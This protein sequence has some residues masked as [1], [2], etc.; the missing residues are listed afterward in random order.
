[1]KIIYTQQEYDSVLIKKI[2]EVKTWNEI[3]DDFGDSV[4]YKYLEMFPFYNKKEDNNGIIT[5]DVYNKDLTGV[6]EVFSLTE[7]M[8]Y[9]T[10]EFTRIK[11]L[12]VTASRRLSRIIN[13]KEK[14]LVWDSSHY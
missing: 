14:D 1:M 2:S 11:W 3:E 12:I 7:G 8:E 5:V 9:P 4:K 13:Y 6:I 10:E